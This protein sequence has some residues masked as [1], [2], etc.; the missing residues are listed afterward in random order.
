[1]RRSRCRCWYHDRV[2][3]NYQ[4]LLSPTRRAP[5]NDLG[6]GYVQ[7]ESI[8]AHGPHRHVVDARRRLK[9]KLCA[10]I[11]ELFL[12]Y[13]SY[14]SQQ[15]N[16]MPSGPADL[17]FLMDFAAREISS[18]EGVAA[19]SWIYGS[20]G[21]LSKMDGSDGLTWL[22][23]VYQHWRQRNEDGLRSVVITR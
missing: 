2:I 20:V 10:W 17:L 15:Y 21:S 18:K 22:L 23:R 16:T 1:M 13:F 6:L 8:K 9:L 4:W 5:I 3:A 12:F 14:C 19:S 7:M 11:L